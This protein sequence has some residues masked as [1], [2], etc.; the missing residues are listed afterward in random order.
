MRWV[1]GSAS[2]RRNKAIAPYELFGTSAAFWMGIQ[3]QHDLERAEDEMANELRKI[4]PA[5]A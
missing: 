5:V 2:K 1:C 4:A 3:A